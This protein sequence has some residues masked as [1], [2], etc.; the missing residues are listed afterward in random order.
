M[1]GK[2][3]KKIIEQRKN[4]KVAKNF[5]KSYGKPQFRAFLSMLQNGVVSGQQ[6]ADD[7]SVSRERVRQWK[8][9]FGKQEYFYTPKDLVVDVVEQGET[10]VQKFGLTAK[11]EKRKL[12]K[13][14]RTI[15]NFINAPVDKSKKSGPK[16]GIAGFRRFIRDLCDLKSGQ[17]IGDQNNMTRQRVM[18]LRKLFG[19]SSRIYTVYPEIQKLRQQRK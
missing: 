16:R 13:L 3:D 9:A 15:K 18:D 2:K 1:P 7:L 4:E 12:T 19:T 6:M 8:I 14:E 10:R 11:G 17:L 5:I